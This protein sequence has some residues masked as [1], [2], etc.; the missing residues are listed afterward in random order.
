MT[1]EH[2]LAT[3]E[4]TLKGLDFGIDEDIQVLERFHSINIE[5]RNIRTRSYTWM[6]PEYRNSVKPARQA[7]FISGFASSAHDLVG[8]IPQME[9]HFDR[10]TFYS[11]PDG[12]DSY[13][14]NS[15]QPFNT[16]SFT[17]SGMALLRSI[18]QSIESGDVL[19]GATIFTHSGGNPVAMEAIALDQ[20]E[21][22]SSGRNRYIT[23]GVL[24]APA[25]IVDMKNSGYITKRAALTTLQVMIDESRLAKTQ[26]VKSGEPNT[27]RYFLDQLSRR[28]LTRKTD[29]VR[30]FWYMKDAPA[31]RKVKWFNMIFEG[32]EYVFDRVPL[33]D[34]T[35]KRLH[36]YWPDVLPHYLPEAT[37]T[38]HNRRLIAH[39]C[40]SRARRAITD[41]PITIV[42]FE[43]DLP[44]PPKG[45][46][47]KEDKKAIKQRNRSKTGTLPQE[48]KQFER[49]LIAQRVREKFPNNSE[50]V[51]VMII[52]L[53]HHVA[54]RRKIGNITESIVERDD[55]R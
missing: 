25:G 29:V 27:A 31:W 53:S 42:L 8:V 30:P 40:T 16:D 52:P 28:G 17:H 55:T 14:E 24:L 37:V 23:Q 44:V 7:V 46:L 51:A 2:S 3:N 45:F 54:H 22:Q 32:L 26:R 5:G 50:N 4:I 9:Q 34:D 13:I 41:T 15:D 47:T 43:E 6:N 21:S 35:R 20:R 12:P 49:D 39:D 36:L 33:L 1:L 19:D 48:K 11:H 18:E 38:K 10:M